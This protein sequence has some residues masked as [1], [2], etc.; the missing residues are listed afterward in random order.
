MCLL[1]N[2]NDDSNTG[3]KIG[4]EGKVV[5]VDETK[6]G[7]RKYNS[8]RLADGQWVFGMVERQSGKLKLEICPQN[9]RD[10]NTLL[11]LINKHVEKGTLI[12]N[13]GWKGYSKLEDLRFKHLSVNHSKFFVD[14]ETGA[15]TQQIESSWWAL[16]RRLSRGGIKFYDLHFAEYLWF[17]SKKDDFFMKLIADIAKIY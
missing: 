5:E 3:E 6:I 17:K 11:T 10:S 7:K 8:G 2:L 1:S 12:M 16:K 14:T 15:H 4:G 13:D 9:Q